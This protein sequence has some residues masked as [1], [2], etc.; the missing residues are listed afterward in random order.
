MGTTTPILATLYPDWRQHAARLADAVRDLDAP[1]LALRASP[2]QLPIWGLAAHTA[3]A[4]VYWL[5]TVI[6]EPGDEAEALVDPTGMGWEDDPAHPRTGDELAW[7]LGVSWAVVAGCLE[8]WTLADLVLPVERV[9]GGVTQVHSRASILNRLFSHDA[10][11]AGEIS[12][13]LG[14][15]GHPG[16][17]LWRRSP[18]A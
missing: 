11:H 16:I 10:F 17:D 13:L 8:R 18:S 14:A 9:S 12:M 6:G 2:G 3:G 4:R 7:A 1:M 5:C 15:Q